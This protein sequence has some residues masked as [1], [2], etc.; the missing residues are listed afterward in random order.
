MQTSH[1]LGSLVLGTPDLFLSN[2]GFAL[3]YPS[4]PLLAKKATLLFNLVYPHRIA[5][6]ETHQFAHSMGGF[7]GVPEGKL[8][9]NS[10]NIA[11]S[12]AR[13]SKVARA[14]QITHN[15]LGCPF[16]HLRYFCEV[17]NTGFWV[18]RN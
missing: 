14:L 13:F 1:L 3:A 7:G 12:L 16:G 5:S 10:I 11:P 6:K 8:K 17:S 18:F 15:C 9:V 2:Q 4:G